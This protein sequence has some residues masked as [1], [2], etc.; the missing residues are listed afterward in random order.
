[1]IVEVKF[2][3]DGEPHGRAYTYTAPD[4]TKVND[5]VELPSGG[6]AVV[7]E[8]EA[9]KTPEDYPYPIKAIKGIV[10]EEKESEEN[11]NE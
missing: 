8:V 11:N 1:M 7:V 6:K 2:L 4:E 3:R 5:T 10:K 9:D